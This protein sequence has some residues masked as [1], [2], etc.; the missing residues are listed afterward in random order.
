MPFYIVGGQEIGGG[1][2]FTWVVVKNIAIDGATIVNV[3]RLERFQQMLDINDVLEV[4]R[5]RM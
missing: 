5:P 1:R 2:D 3:E 4:V